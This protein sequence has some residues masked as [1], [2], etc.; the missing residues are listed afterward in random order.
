MSDNGEIGV[1]GIFFET[2]PLRMLENALK[3]RYLLLY[4]HIY[5][6]SVSEETSLSINTGTS[7]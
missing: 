1:R 2:M 3:K 5:V 6:Q 7:N 4:V